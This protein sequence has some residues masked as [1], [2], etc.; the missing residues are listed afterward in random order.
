[1]RLF[2]F[3]VHRSR[4]DGPE[5]VHF[6]TKYDQTWQACQ[7]SKVVQKSPKGTKMINL[8]VFDHLG[9]FLLS[10][11]ILKFFAWI[12]QSCDMLFSPFTKQKQV[13]V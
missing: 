12:C 9:P 10:R 11:G 13:E 7:R 3:G 6:R 2:Y 5:M 8:S 1:M 4:L